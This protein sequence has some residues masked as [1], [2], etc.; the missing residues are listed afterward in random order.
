[1]KKKEYCPQHGIPPGFPYHRRTEPLRRPCTV[2]DRR[3]SP[4]PKTAA[5]RL[6]PVSSIL[7]GV[8]PTPPSDLQWRNNTLNA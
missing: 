6:E 5:F 4:S 1:M 2:E 7:I 8:H 3:P